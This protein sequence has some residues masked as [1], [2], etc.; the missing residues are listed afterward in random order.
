MALHDVD[1][2]P[3]NP[4]LEYPFPADGPFHVAAPHLHPRYHYP[5]FIGG[6]LLIRR[7]HFRKV[8][9]MSNKYWG[10]GLEDDEFYAR[11]K[12]ADLKVF[13]PANLSTG[14]KDTFRHYHSGKTR[15]R[16]MVKCHNQQEITRRRDRQTGLSST[17]YRVRSRKELTIEGYPLTMLNV[18]LECEPSVTP[19]C[20]CTQNVGNTRP[21][22][23]DSKDRT[24]VIAPLLNRKKHLT[25]DG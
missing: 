8:D 20:N 15:R 17:R 1:L 11:L 5:T 12:E 21:S 18:E 16:D 14:I 19:W 22:A 24:D 9:G 2:I 23:K 13:R 25:P 3:A 7:E 4:G 10:W 6:I